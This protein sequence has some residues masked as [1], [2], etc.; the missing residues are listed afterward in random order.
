MTGGD[1]VRNMKQ[2]IDLLRQLAVVAPDPAVQSSATTAAARLR[3]GIVAASS[4]VT[5]EEPDG[6]IHAVG[7]GA[8]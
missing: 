8:S 7:T 3:R 5:V 1:F 2:V 4:A 6:T